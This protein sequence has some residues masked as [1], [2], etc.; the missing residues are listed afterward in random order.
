A[1]GLLESYSV[2]LPKKSRQGDSLTSIYLNN[3][4]KNLTAQSAHLNYAV[5]PQI[6][7]KQNH[8]ERF[9]MLRRT[10]FAIVFILLLNL[11]LCANVFAEEITTE[12]TGLPPE[13]TVKSSEQ[14]TDGT[15]KVGDTQPTTY[16]KRL[17]YP[18]LSVSA[19]SNFFGKAEADYNQ[20]TKEVSVAYYLRSSQGVATT[21]WSLSYDPSVLKLDTKK[22]TALTVCPNMG[23]QGIINFDQKK[24]KVTYNATDIRLFNFETDGMPFVR[25]VFDVADIPEGAPQITKIDLTIDTLVVADHKKET[26]IVRNFKTADLSKL[27]VKI[28]NSTV[29]TESNYQ[30]PTTVPPTTAASSPTPDQLSSTVDEKISETTVSS[31]K[32]SPSKQ[33]QPTSVGKGKSSKPEANAEPTPVHRGNIWQATILLI[34]M[35]CG[36]VALMLARKQLMLKLMLKD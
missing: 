8:N 14:P 11:I 28:S 6:G 5:L 15:A 18:S 33:A 34:V 27:G 19:I 36:M 1:H 16:V 26:E 29:L 3:L 7:Y 31:E 25:L 35:T 24:G 32:Q 23:E 20:Y 2:S 12:Q 10:A 17:K 13:A 22:N 4:T 21:Q 9:I 30:E